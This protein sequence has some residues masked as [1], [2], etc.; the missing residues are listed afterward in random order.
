ME[1][2]KKED[3][4][5]RIYDQLA[6]LLKKT[7]DPIARMA[8]VCAILHHKMGHYFWTGFYLLKNDKLIVGPYQG[9]VACQELEKNKGVCWATVLRNEAI[10]VPDVHAFSGH[11]ACDSRS[12]SEITLPVY[13]KQNKLRAVFDVDSDR[14]Q[15]FSNM[16][17]VHL[18]KIM[19][20]IY[21]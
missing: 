8:S 1:E 9:P 10:V 18:E 19:Q 14:L 12:Q 2:K 21:S 17:K 15:T 6:G 16:D 5:L 7:N 4:Y 13:D 11:L 3:R 20:L